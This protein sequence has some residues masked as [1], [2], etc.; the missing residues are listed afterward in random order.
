MF[1]ERQV[2]KLNIHVKEFLFYLLVIHFQLKLT[3]NELHFK[4]F[5][6]SYFLLL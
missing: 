1:R 3:L 2:T 5:P 4:M 6:F